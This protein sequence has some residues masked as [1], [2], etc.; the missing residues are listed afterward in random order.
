MS[1]NVKVQF[2]ECF[3]EANLCTKRYRVLMGGAGSGKSVNV[4]QDFILKLMDLKYKGANLLVARKVEQSN[5]NSTFAELCTAISRICGEKASSVWEIKEGLMQ[6]RC[7]ITGCRIIFCG[8]NDSRQKEKIKS[9]NFPHGKLTWIWVEEATEITE[10][11]FDILDDRLR[12]KFE[13]PELFYQITLT[14]N[15]ISGRHWLKKRFFDTVCDD[16][17]THRSTYLDN[18]FIDSGY[19]NR[20]I[21]RKLFDPDGYRVY[22]LGEW[23]MQ[24]GLILTNYEVCEF[25]RDFDSIVLGQDFGFNHANAL[26]AVGFRDGNIYVFDELYE[27]GKDTAELISLAEGRFDK[28][29]VMYCDSAEPDRIKTWRRAGFNAVPVKKGAGSILAQIDYLKS[30]KIF[31]RHVCINLIR[32]LQAWRWHADS[33]GALTDTPFDGFDDAIAALRY[34]VAHKIT[35]GGIEF[36]R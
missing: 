14:F 18:A 19:H 7:R 34:A 30:R 12:G 35:D 1:E 26:L 33:S 20:M 24:E 22:A 28:K 2:N 29:A 13:N 11:D 25:E 36:L 23:G 10:S 21:N 3:R 17:Y 27:Y 6:M 32:E 15:P 5:R 8:F 9:L 31:I 4:A 16:V